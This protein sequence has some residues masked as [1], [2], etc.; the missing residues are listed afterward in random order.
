MS[1]I[2]KDYP[3]DVY[4]ISEDLDVTLEE[5]SKYYCNNKPSYESLTNY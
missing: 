4:Q 3:E 1:D 5:A 2:E